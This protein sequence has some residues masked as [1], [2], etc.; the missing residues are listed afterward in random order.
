MCGLGAGLGCVRGVADTG[1]TGA[2]RVCANPG[3]KV[4]GTSSDFGSATKRTSFIGAASFFSGATGRSTVGPDEEGVPGKVI[5]GLRVAGGIGEGALATG[6]CGSSGRR[7][8]SFGS[9]AGR[10]GLGATNGFVSGAFGGCG[11]APNTCGF[12]WV[13]IS[14]GICG[15]NTGV[16]RRAGDS[17]L[18]FAR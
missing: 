2:V 10:R 12:D 1:G 6:C 11:V 18:K 8:G 3:A 4:F 7:S 5:F 17:P 13:G 16:M 14:T 15:T 9:P